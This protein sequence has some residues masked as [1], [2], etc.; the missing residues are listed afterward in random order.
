MPVG[1]GDFP[2]PTDI[3]GTQYERE[4]PAKTMWYV[5]LYYWTALFKGFCREAYNLNFIKGTLSSL[6]KKNSGIT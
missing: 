6:Q 1:L 5:D 3:H 2:H 4:C